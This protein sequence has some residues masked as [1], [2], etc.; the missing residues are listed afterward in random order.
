MKKALV[1]GGTGAMG[2][3]LI[4]ILGESTE[5]QVDVTSRSPRLSTIPQVR[6]LLGNA[7]ND[8]FLYPLLSNGYDVIIDF[9]NYYSLEQFKPRVEAVMSSCSQYIW[10]SSCRVYSDSD[11]PLTEIS[12]RLLETSADKSFLSS[13]RYALRK[14]RQ[15]DIIK[16]SGYSNYTIIRPYITYSENRL[17][18]GV[19]EKEQ[20]L[21]R[22]LKGRGLV[23]NENVIDKSTAMTY[24][25]DVSKLI[26]SLVGNAGALGQIIQI[27]TGETKT[28][29]EILAIYID[30]IKKERG[31]T[32][33]IYLSS[34]M[35]AIDDIFE[36]GF[37]TT[38]D[39]NFNRSF[40]SSL[41]SSLVEEVSYVKMAIGLRNSLQRFL[42]E[43]NSFLPLDWTYEAYQDA[44]T[45]DIAEEK[46]FG[47]AEEMCLY[48][49][50]RS[51]AV[52]HLDKES[53]KVIHF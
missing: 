10:F 7:L 16:T 5:W 34:K 18:L 25:Y 36:G 20:W 39:R 9:M 29:R 43:N 45:G 28:W 23:I 44:L 8:D 30:V 15:E 31:I 24:G 26:A 22:I 14:A 49:K 38:Y 17:Q 13:N 6:F 27:A 11:I 32:P 35:K 46:E 12:P 47:A 2:M 51:W 1:L 41:V 21:Y 52:N 33:T 37:M 48:H 42:K 53:L 40:N 3:H 50:S 4:R 19:Y